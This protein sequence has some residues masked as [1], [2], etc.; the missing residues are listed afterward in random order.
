[1]FRNGFNLVSCYFR[2]RNG[3]SRAGGRFSGGGVGNALKAQS[4]NLR[5]ISVLHRSLSGRPLSSTPN[6]R[7]STFTVPFRAPFQ[8]SRGEDHE[9]QEFCVFAGLSAR[10]YR[11]DG[12]RSGFGVGSR[13]TAACIPGDAP[14]AGRQRRRR[15]GSIPRDAPIAGRQRRRRRGSIPGDAPIAGRQRRRGGILADAFRGVSSGSYG[16]VLTVGYLRD[17]AQLLGVD[18]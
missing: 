5:V 3:C 8:L 4:I 17:Y 7:A 16:G 1:M 15:R 12:I 13:G 18:C 11:V 9:N 10:S 6:L 2:A 14:I